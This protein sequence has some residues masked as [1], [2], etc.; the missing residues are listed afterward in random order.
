MDKFTTVMMHIKTVVIFVLINVP[1][2]ITT[3]YVISDNESHST[4]FTEGNLVNKHESLKTCLAFELRPHEYEMYSNKTAI[5]PAYNQTFE[6]PF[7]LLIGDLLRICA[8]PEEEHL[9]EETAAQS[10]GFPILEKFTVA[11][12]SISMVFLFTHIIFFVKVPDLRNLPGYNLASLCCSMFLSYLFMLIL[13][14]PHLAQN[15]IACTVTAALIHFFFLGSFLW[16][17]IISFDIFLSIRTATGNLRA[18]SKPFNLKKY[19][20][21]S[22]ICWSISLVFV[23]AALI[24]EYV[25]GIHDSYKPHFVDLSYCWFISELSFVA[26]F[27]GPV[28][29]IIAVN[30]VLFGISAYNMFTNR[31]KLEN[32]SNDTFL[33]K[34]YL[35]YLRLAVIMGVTWTIGILASFLK[36]LVWWYIFSI[37][38]A[39]QGLFIFLAFTCNSKVM[40]FLREKSSSCNSVSSAPVR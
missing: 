8:P 34:K 36:T 6:E 35:T 38:N 18:S 39:F 11:A 1:N 26:F 13:E 3:A 5:V 14:I 15:N 4:V 22:L 37:F 29:T 9:E 20:R 23:T 12:L 25:D 28:F 7:Y 24:A 2:Q 19:I 16:M 32:G 30:F 40:K 17:L 31:M 33:K 27:A 10:L 21:N